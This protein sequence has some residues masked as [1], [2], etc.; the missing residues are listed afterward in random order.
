MNIRRLIQHLL[1]RMLV[2]T[3]LSGLALVAMLWWAHN[4]EVILPLPGGPYS[5][6]RLEFDWTDTSRLDPLEEIPQPARKLNVWVWYPT[7]PQTPASEPAPYLPSE[8]VA[9]REQMDGLGRLLMQNFAHV[10]SCSLAQPPLSAAQSA[11]PLLIMQPG[12]G[13]TIPDYTTLGELLASYGYIVVG[14]TP[15]G[16]AS[17]VV[18]KDG[19]VVKG[20]PQG[21]LP[22]SASITEADRILGALIQ[23]WAADDRFVLDQVERLNASDPAGR[24]T[25]RINLDAVGVIGHSFGG[26]TAAEFCSLDQR[27][28]AGV[29]LDG[30]LYGDVVQ[31]GLQQPFLFMWSEPTKPDDAAWQKASQEVQ[32][33]FQ[34]LPKGSFQVTIR[35]TRHFNFSDASLEYA[36]VLHLLGLLGPVDGRYG[37]QMITTYVRAFFDDTLLRKHDP[38][39]DANP[40]PYPEVQLQLR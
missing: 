31:T 23:V 33:I 4:R 32:A 6:G 38:I 9:A 20:S 34:E 18:F 10:H 28:K 19:Q 15:T 2:L 24:F 8:W 11:Y 25:S 21:K 5:V 30:Y 16:S 29:D 13:P 14:S 40:S 35:G 36:P 26:A 1:P 12:L 7:E 39:L 37:M 22:D 3:I 27:C 17:L